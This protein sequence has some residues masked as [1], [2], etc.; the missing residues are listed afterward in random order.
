MCAGMT[1]KKVQRKKRWKQLRKIKDVGTYF[2]EKGGR[3][4]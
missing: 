2:P 4:Y 3:N 1:H